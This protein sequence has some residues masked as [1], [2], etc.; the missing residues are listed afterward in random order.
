MTFGLIMLALL[1]SVADTRHTANDLTGIKCVVSGEAASLNYSCPYKQ[2]TVY[3]NCNA[4][5]IQ[6]ERRSG[7][8]QTKANHQLVVTRQYVQKYCPIRKERISERSSAEVALAGV[9]L[10]FCCSH[11]REHFQIRHRLQQEI[12]FVFGPR[13]FERLFVPTPSPAP[14]ESAV[15][16]IRP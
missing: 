4:S 7:E 16:R 15:P 12:E 11:C 1:G 2:G 9:A 5:R 6:F 13:N 3:F 8:F 10:R 14:A